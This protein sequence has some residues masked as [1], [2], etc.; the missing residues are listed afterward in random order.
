MNIQPIIDALIAAL[1]DYPAGPD[2][3]VPVFIDGP[4]DEYLASTNAAPRVVAIAERSA[5]Y[6][7][8]DTLAFQTARVSM[9]CGLYVNGAKA[10]GDARTMLATVPSLLSACTMFE[11]VDV[12][13]WERV[14]T[15]DLNTAIYKVAFDILTTI[16]L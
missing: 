3:N 5:E 10:Q 8:T 9:E 16:Q 6:E 14:E 12:T 15:P 1:S 11:S 13:G 4:L 2:G 7:N